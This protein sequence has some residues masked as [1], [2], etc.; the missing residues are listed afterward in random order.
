MARA[1]GPEVRIKQ[2]LEIPSQQRETFY[3]KRR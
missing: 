1:I 3:L 2:R